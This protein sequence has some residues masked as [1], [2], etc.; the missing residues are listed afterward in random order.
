MDE[1]ENWERKDKEFYEQA[2]VG[3]NNQMSD[4]GKRNEFDIVSRCGI[5]MSEVPKRATCPDLNV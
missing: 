4:L 3:I 2:S 5:H 1:R